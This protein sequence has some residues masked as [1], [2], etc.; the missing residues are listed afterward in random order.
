MNLLSFFLIRSFITFLLGTNKGITFFDR[1]TFLRNWKGISP[2]KLQ[3]H[4]H[5]G[6]SRSISVRVLTNFITI[7]G[8]KHFQLWYFIAWQDA[9]EYASSTVNGNDHRKKLNPRTMNHRKQK[10]FIVAGHYLFSL[11]IADV[12][13]WPTPWPIVSKS[14]TMRPR[15]VFFGKIPGTIIAP[16]VCFALL[17]VFVFFVKVPTC[18][19]RVNLGICK[20]QHEELAWRAQKRRER[21]WA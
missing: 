21:L 10:G 7:Y 12:S 15:K 3:C 1:G 20:S 13:S 4:G 16:S 5:D 9:R 17:I 8:N 11:H 6:L 14:A 18:W 19:W 2:T